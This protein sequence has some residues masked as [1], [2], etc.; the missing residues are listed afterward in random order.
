MSIKPKKSVDP[1]AI[2]KT[3]YVSVLWTPQQIQEFA[4]CA[5]PV[6]GPA[7]FMSN[8][9]HIQHP[10]KGKMLYRPY[11][12]QK[13]LINTYNSYRFSVSLCPR[14]S[15]KTTSAA[16]YLLWY[17]MFV[18]DSTILIAAHKYTGAQE[19]MQRV[20][21]A[22]ELC[23]DHIRAGSTTYNKGSIDFEN[24][25][26]IVAQTTTETTGRGMSI[27]LLYLDEFSYVRPNIATA[28]WTSI[29]PTLSTGGKAIIT[30][31]PNSDED[32]FA[33]IWKEAN[34][35]FDEFGNTT[36]LG[37]NG[38]KAYQA[39]W[40]E[41]PDRDET[42]KAEEVG[43]I[44]EDRFRREYACVTGDSGV[45]VKT[46]DGTIM[47]ISIDQLTEMLRHDVKN[48]M[49]LVNYQTGTHVDELVKNNLGLEVLTDSGWSKFDGV[50]IKGKSL[51]ALLQLEV[52]R[53]S[54]TLD[55]CLYLHDHTKIAARQLKPGQKIKTRSGLQR[56]VSISV[57]STEHVYDLLNVARNHRFYA[58]NI[59]AANCEFLIYDETLINAS[60]II[61][62]AGIDPI[63]QQG[64][65]RWYKKPDPYATYVVALDPSL[66]TGGD[67]A[68]IQVLELPTLKQ[69]AEWN[70]N[71]TP[72][73]RQV[74]IM[75]DII[76]YLYETTG[77]E[78]TIYYSVENNTLGEA[79][80]MAIAQVGEENIR[81][82]FL[83]EPS[84]PGVKRSR[85]G[86]TTT[87]KSKLAACAK[88]KSLVEQNKLKIF[89]KSLI[90]ELKTFVANGG[91]YS[92]KQGET[93]DLVMSM[94]LVVRMVQ[95]LQNFD[96]D[97]DDQMNDASDYISP[98][99]F[100]MTTGY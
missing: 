36:V 30:S 40:D 31:T 67:P 17:A 56:V 87:N 78:N 22:Y 66:G 83:T 91:S 32:Q 15:G 85:K 10:T 6:N 37:K 64:Q 58:N 5:C 72:I 75:V 4:M 74:Q 42:W 59:L 19:I 1:Q 33:I 26:R 99:P 12:Y 44:G 16:G 23:P 100:I 71:K 95:A 45:T 73:Q 96:P 79:A 65:I 80:L 61:E 47:T 52:D 39:F 82:I 98:L 8:F 20:R 60:T 77:T 41:H 81:G 70:H 2:V 11:G 3:P 90:S 57:N 62:L 97:L 92:A 14:Q 68:A 28:F 35:T 93:D 21:Y 94:M 49:K 7:Y 27:S 76:Q 55:H 86:F 46:Q 88:F 24:G 18:S 34:K 53:L 69:V 38:F 29:S 54:L 13:N 9:F 84:K 51:T 43:R 50:V 63:E 48:S 25:S 89:S